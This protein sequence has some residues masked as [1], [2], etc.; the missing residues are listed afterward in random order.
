M[1]RDAKSARRTAE[2]AAV[3]RRSSAPQGGLISYLQQHRQVAIET[4]RRLLRA[5]VSLLLSWSVIAVALTLPALF[6]LLMSNV[7]VLAQ[8]LDGAPR[9]SLYLSLDTSFKE[10]AALQQRLAQQPGLSDIAY[11]TP[12]QA[13][14]EFEQ[15]SGLLQVVAG[16]EHNPLPPVLSAALGD[17]DTATLDA[18]ELELAGWSGVDRVQLDRAWVMRLYAI[19]ALGQR[20]SWAVGL[21]LAAGVL[22]IIG[23]TIRLAIERRREEILVVK[24]VG[25]SNS[26]I[27]RPFLYLGLWLGVGGGLLATLLMALLLSLLDGP[28]AQ[29]IKLYAGDFRLQGLGFQGAVVLLLFG[30]G[31]G[32]LGAL[33]ACNRHLGDIEP[34]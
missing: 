14:A 21:L 13:L 12:E 5:P 31:L 29:L 20:L 16:L 11:I 7:Q 30:C 23:N 10:R 27:R 6:F 1:G 15:N 18:L 34:K 4:I 25:G 2:K 32:W 28:V 19:L 33:L 22:L 17:A 24:L 9:V 26:Y 3:N 8:G